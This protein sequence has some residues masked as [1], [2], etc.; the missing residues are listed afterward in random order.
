MIVGLAG[1]GGSG[2]AA[3]VSLIARS[4]A[5]AKSAS[6]KSFGD[7]AIGGQVVTLYHCTVTDVPPQYRREGHFAESTQ[8]YCFGYANGRGVDVSVRYGPRC[9]NR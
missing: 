9:G 7:G 2:D 3:K 5:H 4:D 1:C 6:C 8:H